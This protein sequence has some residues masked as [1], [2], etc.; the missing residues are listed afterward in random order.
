MAPFGSQTRSGSFV[1][2]LLASVM[3]TKTMYIG[4]RG[5]ARRRPP[6]SLLSTLA[7]G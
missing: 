7:V 3:K 4:W 5:C 1:Y 6:A 2:R